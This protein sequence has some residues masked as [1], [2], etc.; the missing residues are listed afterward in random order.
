MNL[1]LS[2]NSGISAPLRT[3]GGSSRQAMTRMRPESSSRNIVSGCVGIWASPSPPCN[4]AAKI[5]PP[6]WIARRMKPRST[7]AK[8]SVTSKVV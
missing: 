4:R 6:A 1:C 3:I 2:G 5:F 7:S 8:M